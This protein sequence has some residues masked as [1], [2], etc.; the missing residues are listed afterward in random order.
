M[1][2]YSI[3]CGHTYGLFYGHLVYFVAIWYILWPFGIGIFPLFGMEKSGDPELKPDFVPHV[4]RR[5]L[6][7]KS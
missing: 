3:F 4:K 2:D 5:W 7:N 1:E 6:K